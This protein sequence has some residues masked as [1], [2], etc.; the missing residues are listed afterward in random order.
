MKFSK[1]QK[2]LHQ[3]V[4]QEYEFFIKVLKGTLVLVIVSDN[5]SSWEIHK[6][7][8][9]LVKRGAIEARTDIYHH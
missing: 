7:H 1:V 9:G 4:I 5:R 6:H 2:L 3:N 8:F